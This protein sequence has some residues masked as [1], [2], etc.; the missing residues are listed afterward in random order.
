MKYFCI[1]QLKSIDRCSRQVYNVTYIV[2]ELEISDK[3]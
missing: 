2:R 3:V 1:S